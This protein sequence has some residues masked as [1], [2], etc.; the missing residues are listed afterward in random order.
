MTSGTPRRTIGYF[1]SELSGEWALRALQGALTAAQDMNANIIAFHGQSEKSPV[2]LLGQE[3]I[4]YEL[5]MKGRLDGLIAWKGHL[6]ERLTDDETDV[7]YRRYG[8]PVV[9]I[10]G[11]HRGFPCVTYGNREGVMLIVNHLV[12]TH[13]MGRIAYLGLTEGHAGFEARYEGYREALRENGLGLDEGLIC[14]YNTWTRA[15]E[16]RR[17]DQELDGW[18]KAILANG[19]QAI[20]GSCD[21]NATWAMERLAGIG[22]AV[23]YDIAVVGFDGFRDSWLCTPP[24]TTVDPDWS[25]LGRRSVEAV[26][27]LISRGSCAEKIM[28]APR[29][30]VSET[31]GCEDAS[32]TMAGAKAGIASR[33]TVAGKIDAALGERSGRCIGEESSRAFFAEARSRISGAF[34]KA[35]DLILRECFQAEDDHAAWQNVVSLLENGARARLPFRSARERAVRLGARARLRVESLAMQRQEISRSRLQERKDKEMSFGLELISH[36]DLESIASTLAAGLPGLGVERAYVAL[37]EDPRPYRY[38]DPAPEWSR[39]VFAMD[40]KARLALPAGGL[41]FPSRRIVPDELCRWEEKNILT[42]HDLRYRDR[43]LGFAVFDASQASGIFFESLAA[44]ISSALQGA[45]LLGQVNSQYA[46][47]GRGIDSLSKSMGEITAHIGVISES[48]GKQSAAMDES[49]ESIHRMKDAVENVAGISERA[50]TVSRDLDRIT[51]KSV[52]SIKDLL[53]T[54]DA[55]QDKS[56]DVVSLLLLIKDVSDRTKLLSLNAAIQAARAGENG[57]GFGVV[58]KEIRGLAESAEASVVK[59]GSVIEALND[60]VVRASALSAGIEGDLDGILRGLE[61]NSRESAFI[62]G[63]MREQRQGASELLRAIAGLVDET[64]EIKAA[65]AAQV[66]ATGSFKDA[67]VELDRVSSTEAT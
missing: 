53:R 1:N 23:P 27:E 55:V 50:A 10:E 45:V 17:V 60:A 29:L 8:V 3:N 21:P 18:L 47:L 57:K 30:V 39:M 12:K 15:P 22:V 19:A 49:A 46:S 38:P 4:I 34:E 35:F 51:G 64:A 11:Q 20:I 59:I 36:F 14:P 6:T 25:E 44:Q 61:S 28:V 31:C 40:E 54:I 56:R 37:F 16:G 48:V 9:T 5:A 2:G 7:F 52:S 42:V 26:M 43:Q 24:L 62:E 58:A 33:R 65:V 32:R 41:R 67:L 13:R 63:A 66:K